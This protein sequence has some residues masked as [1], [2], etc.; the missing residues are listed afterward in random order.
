MFFFFF[1]MCCFELL[2]SQLS[3]FVSQFPWDHLLCSRVMLEPV[4]GN[5][6]SLRS[7]QSSDCGMCIFVF[8]L[9]LP[10]SC[11][12]TSNK[13]ATGEKGSLLVSF[14]KIRN[15]AWCQVICC[16][17]YSHKMQSFLVVS[18]VLCTISSQVCI[19]I[20]GFKMSHN[21]AMTETWFLC[22]VWKLFI[23][24]MELELTSVAAL[25]RNSISNHIPKI[26]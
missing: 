10:W 17:P 23:V 5:V 12:T 6:R 20:P 4:S 13:D 24:A 22:P 11:K 3:P 14:R 25:S 1:F 18:G 2:S 8:Y 26:K 16:S 9:L 7:V 19:S 15:P 21:V